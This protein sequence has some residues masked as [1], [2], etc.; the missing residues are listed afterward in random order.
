MR[1]DTPDPSDGQTIMSEV[2]TSPPGITPAVAERA[3]AAYVGF[4]SR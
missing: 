1:N 2:I 3:I 4:R